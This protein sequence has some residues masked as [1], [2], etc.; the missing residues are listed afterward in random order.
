MKG[1]YLG[2]LHGMPYAAKD[3]IDTAG[4]RTTNGSKLYD[5]NYPSKDAFCIRKFND[6]GAI[7]LGKTN[8]HQ[9]AAAS[10]TINHFYGTTKNPHDLSRIAGGS[11]G[12]SASAVASD[13][14]P[15]ALGTDTGGSIR[16]PSS[17]C[18]IVGLKPTHGSISLSGVF[19]NTPSIDHVGPMCQSVMS[20][21]IAYE[22]LQGFDPADPKSRRH[23]KFNHVSIT[24]NINNFR[25]A[26]C[27]ELYENQ[28]LDKS[29]QIYFDNTIEILRECGAQVEYISLEKVDVSSP[30]S[31]LT[32][33]ISMILS[34][35]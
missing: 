23:E 11:S 13:M 35:L 33:D 7:L 31:N 32:A 30:S 14:A 10:T 18:G 22:A 16:T 28:E 9:Y 29:V 15:I 25:I 6:C 3:I 20:A 19:P 4:I 21:A 17:L 34:L 2:P 24:K 5:D 12:G 27:P 26:L 8:T 1:E